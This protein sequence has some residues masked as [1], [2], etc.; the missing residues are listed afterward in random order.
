MP[1]PPALPGTRARR[2]W[3]E[4]GDAAADGSSPVGGG[5]N[6]WEIWVRGTL[7]DSSTWSTSP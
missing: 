6:H 5:V 1:H 7:R 3:G 4:R 2:S